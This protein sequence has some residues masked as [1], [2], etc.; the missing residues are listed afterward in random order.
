MKFS[1]KD[2]LF[3]CRKKTGIV[4]FIVKFTLFENERS[5]SHTLTADRGNSLFFPSREKIVLFFQFYIRK[6]SAKA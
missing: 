3:A 4:E 6:Q 1:V 2:F 5:V